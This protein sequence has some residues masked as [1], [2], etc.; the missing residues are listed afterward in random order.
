MMQATKTLTMATAILGF[1][2]WVTAQEAGR[3]DP[4]RQDPMNPDRKKQMGQ[5]QGAR[6]GDR[7]KSPV[8]AILKADDLI[9][10]NVVNPEGKT[11]GEIKNLA[12]DA[13]Q[14]TIA[15][16]I[17]SF[18]GFLGIGDKLFAIPWQALRVGPGNDNFVL[19]VTKEKLEKAPGFDSDKWP[20]LSNRTHGTELHAYYGVSPYWDR[21]AWKGVVQPGRDVADAA[22]GKTAGDHFNAQ[23]VQTISGRVESVE[24]KDKEGKGEVVVLMVKTTGNETLKVKLGPKSHVEAQNLEFKENDQVEV[25]GS[26]VMIDGKQCIIATEV[27]KD[28]RTLRLR[29]AS[30][31][32]TWTT[33]REGELRRD[34]D[35]A[36]GGRENDPTRR[37][38]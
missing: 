28:G 17:L 11:L 35:P 2:S 37:D 3:N 21:A 9:G 14:G 38:R 18:G 5:D 33:G 29:D 26:K 27:R 10:K 1:C 19:N 31:K 20:D 7:S 13:E 30:G 6:A 4:T 12:I 24:E 23:S 34:T 8:S 22:Y 16:A 15:Y 36:R 32:P 25:T